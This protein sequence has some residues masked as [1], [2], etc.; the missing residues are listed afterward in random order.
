MRPDRSTAATVL[1]LCLV[2]A[3]IGAGLAK[4]RDQAPVRGNPWVAPK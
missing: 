4:A 3:L 2:A 1:A